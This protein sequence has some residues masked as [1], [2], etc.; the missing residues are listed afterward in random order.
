MLAFA[1]RFALLLSLAR[2][3]S[4]AVYLFDNTKAETAGNADWVTAP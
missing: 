2:P 3:L 1:L 4:A